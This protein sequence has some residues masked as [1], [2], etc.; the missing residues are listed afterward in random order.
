MIYTL[1]LNPAIDY[2][3]HVGKLTSGSIMRSEYENVFFG[4][5]GINV[6][7]L[8]HEHKIDTVAMGFI[9]GFT[10]K[11]IEHGLNEKGINTD[12]IYLDNGFTRI[13][14]KIRA[15]TETDINGKGPFISA[16]N[17]SQLAEKLKILTSGDTLVLA[18]SIPPSVPDDIYEN[19]MKEHYG[20]NINYVVDATG[21]LLLNS[22]KYNP[23]LIKPNTDELGEIF[24]VN[25]TT[26]EDAYKY[27]LKLKDKGA[28]NVL[29]SMGGN[30]AVLLDETGKQHYMPAYKGKAVNT[31]GAGDSM[32]AGFIAGYEKTGD[33]EYAL[34]LGTASGSATAF[35]EGL[36]DINKI[37]Q[38]LKQDGRNNK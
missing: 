37:N 8:L 2:V 32:I 10:G 18:G 28:R 12:F 3:A 13:N 36:A 30:G 25:I 17:L 34:K 19:I 6:S 11:A 24:S 35:S 31:V 26:T 20:K 9:A 33:Y 16:E 23:F 1:T 15:E 22:L 4:G 38:L 7:T 21:K 27:A 29:V 5:K 14:V